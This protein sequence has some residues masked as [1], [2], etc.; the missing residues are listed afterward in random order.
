M[1]LYAKK[2]DVIVVGGG[3]AG[4][5]AALAA[6]RM[7]ASTLMLNLYLDNT[8]MMPCNPSI[9]GPAKGHL[10][11]EISAI[12]G[13]QAEAADAST[14]LV[15]M[16][17]TSK[18]PA[19]RALRAQCDL[20]E[21]ERYFTMRIQTQPGLDVRQEMVV[22]LWIEDGR[23][24]GVGTRYGFDY[25]ARTMV[26]ATGAFLGSRVHIGSENFPSGPLGQPPSTELAF[27]LEESGLA[28]RRMRTDT[29]PR[30]HLDTLDLAE[31][32][33]QESSSEP[34]SFS[35][36]GEG[37]VHSGYSCYLTRSNRRTHD[38]VRAN[39][40]RSPLSMGWIQGAG[41][42]YCPSIEAKVI[43]FPEKES[44]QLFLEPVSRGNR[45]VYVQNFSTSLPLD[46]QLEMV[47]TLPGCE[48]AF[49][50]R[51]GYAIEYVCIDPTMLTPW[52]EM[53]HV[54]GLFCAGQINGTSGYEEAAAQG[55]LAGIN[56]AL[57]AAGEDPLVLKR[58]D[59]YI[60]VLVDDLVTKGS[61]EPYRMLTSRCE[62]RLLL[63]HDNAGRRLAPFGRR[64][65]LIDDDRWNRITGSW[66]RVDSEL[67][68]LGHAR[69]RPS[70]ELNS[71]LAEVGSSRLEETVS[72]I[73]LLSR[74]EVPY[75]L[76]ARFSPSDDPPV[77]EEVL[78]VETEVKYRGYIER[79]E[80]QVARMERME[81][82]SLPG[83][84]DYDAIPG[85]LA[86]SRQK[87]SS[88]RPVTL[89]QAGRISGV[90]PADVHILSVWLSSLSRRGRD[91]QA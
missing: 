7:G 84:M 59:S 38:I 1:A 88:I 44:H 32:I 22:G 69:V 87:L 65:G 62:H 10:V 8:A 74:P 77:G 47:H 36:W 25:E 11:R 85:L 83:D 68:R 19:V 63:R 15:R 58:S 91:D 80:R 67:E 35:L 60:G 6:A 21:Y 42:R 14:M 17:N 90:T 28:V 23:I 33:E 30:L 29:S 4:C 41:P 53:K 2:Y 81:E 9:G 66:R 18:G 70:G 31:L 72:A 61:D 39:L 5:E 57:K 51:P 24:R 40:D 82:V 13:E 46:A 45:E 3:H 73:E 86:E 89:G 75:G 55:L 20:K 48:R 52:L 71:A 79:Q 56:A 76:V 26:L 78:S 50:T 16:L 43:N 37:R 54:S 34:L 12:G 64:L 49:I 27:S